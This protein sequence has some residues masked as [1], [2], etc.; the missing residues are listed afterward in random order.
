MKDSRKV[1]VLDAFSTKAECN[2]SEPSKFASAL[3]FFCNLDN[4]L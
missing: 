1:V 2:A 3:T 4:G